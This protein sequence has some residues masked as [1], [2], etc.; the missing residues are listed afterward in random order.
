[1]VTDELKSYSINIANKFKGLNAVDCPITK[2][3]ID[4]VRSDKGS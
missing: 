3:R 1:M 4:Q 2:F